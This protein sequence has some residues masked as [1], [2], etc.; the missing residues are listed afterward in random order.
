MHNDACQ[1]T[2]CTDEETSSDSDDCSSCCS[3]SSSISLTPPPVSPIM[4]DDDIE[5]DDDDYVVN[6]DCEDTTGPG[7]SMESSR[8]LLQ[9]VEAEETIR[10]EESAPAEELVC[11]TPPKQSVT[12]KFGGDNADFT[13]KARFTRIDGPKDNKSLH[14]FHIMSVRDRV[15]LDHLPITEPFSCLNSPRN[16]ALQLL[17]NREC[18]SKL[19]DSLA[20]L[21]SRKMVSYIPYFEFGFSDVVTWHITHEYYK[22]ISQKSEVVS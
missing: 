3:Y 4:S 7:S 9:S 21:V 2:V 6:T 5:D 13:V 17:P 12:Y 22:E 11:A 16:I 14:Y 20:V 18:D 19:I 15:N 10:A 1:N 8:S